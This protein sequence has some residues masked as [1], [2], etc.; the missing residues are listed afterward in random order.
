MHQS[1]GGIIGIGLCT[2]RNQTTVGIVGVLP[3]GASLLRG[4]QLIGGIVAVDRGHRAGT[5]ILFHLQDIAC[6]VVGV[7]KAA[8]VAVGRA[9]EAVVSNMLKVKDK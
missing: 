7:V 4:V 1:I 2:V 8:S 6:R 3:G 9:S 5:E